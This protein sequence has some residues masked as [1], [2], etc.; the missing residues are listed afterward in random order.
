M[1]VSGLA[2]GIIKILKAYF[3]CSPLCDMVLNPRGQVFRAPHPAPPLKGLS[4]LG[5]VWGAI[6]KESLTTPLR[7]KQLEQCLCHVRP[8]R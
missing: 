6:G 1:C 7:C 3:L 2:A 8:S 4:Q 5:R